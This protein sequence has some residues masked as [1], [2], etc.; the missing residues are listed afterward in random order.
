M[1]ET[2]GLAPA[3]QRCERRSPLWYMRSHGKLVEVSGVAPDSRV[4]QT[5]AIT[6]SAWPPLKRWSSRT[7]S[8]RRLPV[9]SRLLCS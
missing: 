2:T 9:I 8:R 4:L 7:V 5:R 1:V 6:R 3:Q